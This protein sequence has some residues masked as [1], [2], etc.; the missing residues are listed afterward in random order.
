MESISFRTRH[1]HLDDGTIV[2]GWVRC[3]PGEPLEVKP[4]CQDSAD[5]HLSDDTHIALARTDP[6]VHFRESYV[7]SLEEFEADPYHPDDLSYDDLVQRVHAANRLYNTFRGS[8]AALRSGI[9]LI[10]AMGNTPWGPIG[11]TR[12]KKTCDQY[13]KNSWVWSHVW[14][15]M[16]PD[17]PP[18]SG[19]EE[20]DFGSTFGGSGLSATAREAMYM[21]RKGGMVSYHNDQPRTD[22]SLSEFKA[23][24]SPPDYLLQPLYFDG[25]TVL[26]CQTDTLELARKANL[27]SLL[28]R[29]IPTGPA[30]DMLIRARS[31]HPSELPTEIGLDYLYFNRDMLES[32]HTRMINYRR[33]AL[34]SEQD[35]AELIALTRER[36]RARDPLAFL[37]TDH[38]PHPIEA[39][40]FNDEGLPGSPGTRLLEHS[41]QVHMHLVLKHGFTHADIDWLTAK[42]PAKYMAQSVEFPYPVGEMATGAMANLVMFHPD[43]PY[44]VEED[45]L[46]RELCDPHYHTAYRDESLNGRVFYTVVHGVAFD[47]RGQIHPMNMEASRVPRQ[48]GWNPPCV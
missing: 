45:L 15:R 21:Q 1:L 20:K 42:A 31:G 47:V 32:R 28:T 7:P 13:Q 25:D 10:G 12:W 40:R 14:P 35:Q 36:G 44:Q 2:P 3:T 9:W 26:A 22:E 19:Q 39:K 29:H 46:R 41:H 23:R 27:K 16:E 11:E 34:P 17:V 5:V 37:G 48:T 33:P 6:H 8:L 30:L 38:A 18:I 43:K 24:V 4:G